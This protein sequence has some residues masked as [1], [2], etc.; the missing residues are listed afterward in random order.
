MT[1]KMKMGAIRWS[2]IIQQAMDYIQ[3][4]KLSISKKAG[5]K[6]RSRLLIRLEAKSKY[7]CEFM[8]TRQ[9]KIALNQA[10]ETYK[11]AKKE[12]VNLRQTFL[13]DLAEAWEKEGRG[14][15]SS[16]LKNLITLEEQRETF[17]KLRRIIIIIITHRL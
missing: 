3:Y 6:I 14:H 7:N 16:I 12:H 4:I 10:Y 5:K 9:R 2:P 17:R 15:K 8:T 1:R 13:E 11:Q